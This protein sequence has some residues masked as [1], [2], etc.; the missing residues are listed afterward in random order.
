MKRPHIDLVNIN[1]D[2]NSAWRWP[3]PIR[4]AVIIF[5]TLLLAIICFNYDTQNELN[6]LQILNKNEMQ[7]KTVF[8]IK[9]KQ[10]EKQDSLLEL[11]NDLKKTATI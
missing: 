8:E 2:L 1:W 7:L 11:E 9:Q 3:A 6:E 4:V 5:S 10:T